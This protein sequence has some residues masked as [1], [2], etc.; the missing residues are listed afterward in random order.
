MNDLIEYGYI[1]NEVSFGN[2]IIC[3]FHKTSIFI[4]IKRVMK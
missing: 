4:I 3:L 2:I 1:N